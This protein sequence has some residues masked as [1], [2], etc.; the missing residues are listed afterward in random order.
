MHRSQRQPPSQR[1]RTQRGRSRSPPRSRTPSRRR[2]RR[3]SRSRSPRP[4]Q[5]PNRAQQQDGQSQ[6][7]DHRRLLD[8]WRADRDFLDSGV[9]FGASEKGH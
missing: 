8:H 2:H 9:W 6:W 5:L 4:R 1:S 7:E 3:H